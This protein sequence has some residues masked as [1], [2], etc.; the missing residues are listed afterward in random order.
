MHEEK[1]SNKLAHEVSLIH[2]SIDLR[3]KEYFDLSNLV[4]KVVKYDQISNRDGFHLVDSDIIKIGERNFPHTMHD[5]V[6]SSK[7]DL[8]IL[9]SFRTYQ[10]VEELQLPF[11]VMLGPHNSSKISELSQV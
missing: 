7:C 8:I 2:T 4:F 6:Q 10:G 3:S 5:L 11:M 9:E 1:A